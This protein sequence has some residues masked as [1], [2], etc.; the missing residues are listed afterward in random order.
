[1]SEQNRAMDELKRMK[2]GQETVVHP[3]QGTHG[4]WSNFPAW[5]WWGMGTLLGL[6]SVI[7]FSAQYQSEKDLSKRTQKVAQRETLLV[8][9]KSQERQLTKQIAELN[10]KQTSLQEAV[11]GLQTELKASSTVVAEYRVIKDE[12]EILT[13]GLAELKEKQLEQKKLTISASEQ[14][15]QLSKTKLEA[16]EQQI[17]QKKVALLALESDIT[18]EQRKFDKLTGD[19]ELLEAKKAKLMNI[20]TELR[21][22]EESIKQQ[23]NSSSRDLTRVTAQLD[24]VTM[25]LD[26]QDQKLVQVQGE[27]K[28]AGQTKSAL[29]KKSK[30]KLEATEDQISQKHVALLALESNVTDEQ[31]KFD[32]LTGINQAAIKFLQ[33][34]FDKSNSAI[35]RSHYAA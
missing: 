6:V 19:V 31:R 2:A 4:R 35:G 21:T 7:V 5:I 33:Q 20:S 1:M 10:S 13:N 22:M 28:E 18:D 12:H 3:E 26:T 32:K 23:L 25:Q 24:E 11:D 17:S 29:E 14:K 15:L 27:L 34:R 8:E 9:F 30:M 16:T